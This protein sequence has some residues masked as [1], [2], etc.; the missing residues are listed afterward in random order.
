[1]SS[2]Y[3]YLIDYLLPSTAAYHCWRYSLL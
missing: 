1:M 3:F 2:G